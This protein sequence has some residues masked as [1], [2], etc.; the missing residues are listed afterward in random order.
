V[1]TAL[2]AAT[3]LLLCSGIAAGDSL[4]ERAVGRFES[5]ALPYLPGSALALNVDGM[6]PPY[7][8]MLIGPGSIDEG[9]YHAPDSAG[10]DSTLLVAANAYG[11]AA[12]TLELAP[13]PNPEQPFIAVASYDD[14]VIVHDATPPYRMRSVLGI[15]GAPGDV[16][17]DANGVLAS[18]QTDGTSAILASLAPW[19][20]R[21]VPGVLLADE[22]A[23][24]ERTHALFATDRDV[25]GYG[26]LTRIE[27]DGTVTRRVLGMTA[28]GIAIDERRRRVYVANVN[29]GTVSEVDA[30][31]LV[32]IRR[33]PT[34]PRV[35][36]LALSTD[37]SRLFA[38]SNQSVSSPFAHAG[39]VIAIDLRSRSPRVVARSPALAFPVGI[40]LD[41]SR[42]RLF[43]TDELADAVYVLSARTLRPVHAP[44]HTCGIPWK[45]TID[46]GRLYIPCAR[47]DQI[48]LF[49]LA[50]LRREHGAPF[51]T[52]GYPLAVAVWH[53]R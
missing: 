43:V 23:F 6:T 24:D 9:V 30:D 25:N 53:G 7:S 46:D 5:A 51:A 19:S 39:G 21:S 36:S 34:I 50:T 20:V 42:G 12:R 48:D 49:D 28:E 1:R 31:S 4:H 40:A 22:L 16:A 18:A 13:P 17:I 10:A 8:V 2:L 14:G 41:A 37:G 45:P 3:A 11:L 35:F 38:V 52:G 15:G 29:D 27:P 26:A 47:S 44:L 32:E 33:F